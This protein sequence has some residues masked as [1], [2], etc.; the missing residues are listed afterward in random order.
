[1]PFTFSHPAAAIPFRRYGLVI[2]A[3]VIGSMA[4]DIEYF[5]R[6]AQQ[7]RSAHTYPGV[8]TIAFPVALAALAVFHHVMKWPCLSLMPR[9]W[10]ARLVTSAGHFRWRPAKHVV[11]ILISLMIGIVTHLVWDSF[12]H[13][14][15]WIVQQVPGMRSP[16]F[17]VGQSVISPY[18][19]AQH[20]ST[21]L[22]GLFIAIIVIMCVRRMPPSSGKL[23]PALPGSVSAVVVTIGT[24]PA[25]I[26]GTLRAE[27]L[28]MGSK[29]LPFLQSFVSG[30][31]V[32]AVSVAVIEAL[33]FSC[34][35]W[36]WIARAAGRW[37]FSSSQWATEK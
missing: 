8:L 33:L 35:W 14:E 37:N 19:L 7:D 12:T 17:S 32:T 22:G 18:K 27:H 5:T 4:P 9:S 16:L 26:T 30:F 20:V 23:P 36:C 34:G 11:L 28:A 3:L 31:V 6:L 2:S 13:K 15:G 29:G 1:M 24:I 25:L 21:V 10:Q